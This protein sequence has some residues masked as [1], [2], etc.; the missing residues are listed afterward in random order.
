MKAENITQVI[1]LHVKFL[2]IKIDFDRYDYLIITSKQAVAAL[3]AFNPNWKNKSVLAISSATANAVIRAGGTLLDVGDGYGDN[4]GGIICSY[5]KT[6]RWLYTRAKEIAS[7][8]VSVCIKSGFFVDEKIVYETSCAQAILQADIPGKATLIFTS[9]SSVRCFL[10][11]HD[12]ARFS[13]I[14]VI[15]QTTARA[16]PLH[17]KYIVADEPTVESCIKKAK[18]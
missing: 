15:G 10:K 14:I 13:H 5:P 2:K 12:L 7:D 1:S 18:E 6:T 9:P 17:V 4:L 8:F 16:L 3:E 11:T